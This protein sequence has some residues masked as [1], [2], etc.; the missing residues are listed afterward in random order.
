MFSSAVRGRRIQRGWTQD[1][2][3]SQS[4]TGEAESLSTRT[5]NRVENYEQTHFK[6]TTLSLIARALKTNL[7]ELLFEAGLKQRVI[8]HATDNPRH[9]EQKPKNIVGLNFVDV[10]HTFRG[11]NE[12][13]AQLRH[14][15]GDPRA[16]FICIAGRSGIGKTALLS[17]VCDEIERGELR[18]SETSTE[19]GVDG[20]IYVSCRGTNSLTVERL[21]SYVGQLLGETHAEV[22]MA[23]WHDPV[24]SFDDKVRF[25]LSHLRNGCYLLALDHFEDTL[26]DE[27]TIA[28]ADFPA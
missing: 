20:I 6:A 24:L 25:L 5:I 7:D 10:S 22:V 8:S 1:Q 12:E 19:M 16:K 18:L 17:K 21:F 11:R 27:N 26:I 2:L 13:L 3:A 23:C 9:E 15:L 14:L 28:D 4:R